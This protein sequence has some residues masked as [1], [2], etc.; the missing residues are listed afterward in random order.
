[1][2]PLCAYFGIADPIVHALVSNGR[3][4]IN[5]DI[6]YFKCQACGWCKSSRLNTPMVGGGHPAYACAGKGLVISLP[7]CLSV[8]TNK[9]LTSV[10][11]GGAC[12]FFIFG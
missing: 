10:W 2:N 12:R 7:G 3:Q 6:P 8:L 1:L 9:K 5:R 4:G 11:A